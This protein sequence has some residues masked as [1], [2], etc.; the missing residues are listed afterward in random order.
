MN[1]RM[2]S[3]EDDYYEWKRFEN[4]REELN[5]LTTKRTTML[6]GF[7]TLL[8]VQE[9]MVPFQ[10]RYRPALRFIHRVFGPM[11][12]V[13][14]I[15]KKLLVTAWGVNR[16]MN[17]VGRCPECGRTWRDDEEAE[18]HAIGFDPEEYAITHRKTCHPPQPEPEP[19]PRYKPED[20]ERALERSL[21]S[22][23]PRAPN[24]EEDAPRRRSSR[25]GRRDFIKPVEIHKLE[26]NPEAKA[27][28]QE[29]ESGRW[30]RKQQRE[31]WEALEKLKGNKDDDTPSR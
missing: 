10:L 4:A 14:K 20:Y 26:L 11:G 28:L 5:K 8:S 7:S 18:A 2:K 3:E 24:P 12:A 9:I 6:G 30:T 19:E 22:R 21:E 25:R 13:V 23:K 27:R 17:L 16:V 1:N 15:G 31:Y 29:S